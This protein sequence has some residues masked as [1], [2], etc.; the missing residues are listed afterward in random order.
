MFITPEYE[1]TLDLDDSITLNPNETPIV[2]IRKKVSYKLEHPYGNCRPR[3]PSRLSHYSIY[4]K[5]RSSRVKFIWH[6]QGW[7]WW[8]KQCM[9]QCLI[10]LLESECKCSSLLFPQNR[11]LSLTLP[12]CTYKARVYKEYFKI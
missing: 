1:S 8:K 3:K 2:T 5:P 12:I 10:T 9:Q 7:P 4:T 11:N 6:E